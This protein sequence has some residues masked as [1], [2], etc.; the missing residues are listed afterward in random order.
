MVL[1]ISAYVFSNKYSYKYPIEK[2]TDDSS[3]A[4]DLQIRNA[5]FSTTVQRVP[6]LRSSTKDIQRM[7][8][9]LNAQLFTLN[10]NLIQT[11]LTCNDSLIVQ[12]LVDTTASNLSISIC[13][14]S[15]NNSILSLVIPLP[16]QTINVQLS[17]FGL[18]TIGAISLGLNGPSA[19][20]T[21]N[22]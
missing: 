15:Q 9:L 13:Q 21:D 3:F 20:T 16:T 22:R 5:K 12:R 10:I 8:D 14:T 6:N 19:V 1:I 11:A 4:C 17:L 18:K 2:S 7:F